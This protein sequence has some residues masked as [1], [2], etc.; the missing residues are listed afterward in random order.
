MP[1]TARSASLSLSL[2]VLALVIAVA[3]GAVLALLVT[4]ASG[5]GTRDQTLTGDPDCSFAHFTLA[6]LSSGELRQEFVPSLPFLAGA[7]LCLTIDAGTTV[8]LNVRSGT[9]TTP[10]P[11]LASTS[12][13]PGNGG[14][15][16]V[17]MDLPAPLAVTPGTMLVLEVPHSYTHGFAWWGTCGAVTGSCTSI[18]P[19]LYPAGQPGGFAGIG[20]FGFRTYG[21]STTPS[22]IAVAKGDI[23]CDGAVTSV[24][25]LDTLRVVALLNVTLPAGCPAVTLGAP[26]QASAAG[27]DFGQYLEFAGPGGGRVEVPDDPALNPT[28]AITIEARINVRSYS[29]FGISGT[30]PFIVGKQWNHAW[31]LALQCSL[32]G[33]MSGYVQGSAGGAFA[34]NAQVPLNTWTHLAMT[35]GASGLTYYING[36]VDASI[37][38]LSGPL[39]TSEADVALQIGNDNSWDFSPDGF[40]NEVRIWNVARTQAEIQAAMDA[41]ISGPLPGL[42]VVWHFDG[43]ANDAVGGHDGTLHGDVQFA[44]AAG[45][46][47]PSPTPSPSPTPNPTP[48][49]TARGDIDCDGTITAVD[50]LMLLRYVAQLNVSLPG[51]CAPIGGVTPAVDGVA[52]ASEWSDAQVAADLP[53]GRLLQKNDDANLYL[54]VDLTGDTV[55]DPPLPSIPWGERYFTKR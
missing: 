28:D 49:P 12:A 6:A 51:G 39:G 31:A 47:T 50:A 45:S 52:A 36:E 23:D 11:V 38:S 40:I 44:S 20:D 25:A 2:V 13:V 33:R 24:D 29:G 26:A 1:A 53:H 18:D 5:H 37:P 15:Q 55:D 4:G 7:D 8:E 17:H 32:G 19:D 48:A 54:L 10:G 43:D 46:P 41:P 3:T 30:C 16:Y 35:Y 42:V 14:I 34:G 22:P 27:S 21:G 9:A